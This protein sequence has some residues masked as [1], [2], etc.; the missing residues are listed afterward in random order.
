MSAADEL[1]EFFVH[2]VT[3]VTPGEEGPWGPSE[4]TT[5]DPLRCFIDD[6]RRL[7]RDQ[8]GTEVVSESSLTGPLEHHDQYPVGATVNLP[9]RQ[10][11]VISV[12]VADGRSLDLPDH[13]QVFV[14]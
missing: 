10:A 8:Q 5:S 2:S 1:E 4:G 14:T 6:T 3:V 7:V 13:V 9:Y 12:S 11:E